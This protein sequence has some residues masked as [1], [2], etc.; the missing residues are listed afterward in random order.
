MERFDEFYKNL[1][2]YENRPITRTA[3]AYIENTKEEFIKYYTS[4]TNKYCKIYVDRYLKFIQLYI[5]LK[6]KP[7]VTGKEVVPYIPHQTKVK[8]P[9]RKSLPASLQIDNANL[10]P[11]DL[12]IPIVLNVSGLETEGEEQRVIM[13]KPGFNFE[14]GLRLDCLESTD[15]AK[16][17]DFF[18][19]AEC[20]H[21]TLSDTGKTELVKFLVAAKIKGAAKSRLGSCTVEAFDILKTTCINRI[22][23][24]EASSTLQLQLTS[25]SQGR[26]TLTEYGEQLRSLAKRLALAL[27]REQNATLASVETATRAMA[28]NQFKRGCHREV[29]P[30]VLAASPATLEEAVQTAIASNLDYTPASIMAYSNQ[31]YHGQRGQNYN[32]NFGRPNNFSN[33]PNSSNRYQNSQRYQNSNNSNYYNNSNYSNNRNSNNYNSKFNNRDRENNTHPRNDNNYSANGRGNNNNRYD[34]RRNNTG[35]RHQVSTID[36]QNQNQQGN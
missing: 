1:S 13:A 29:Q 3:L 5:R 12:S 6:T 20:Y 26:K 27:A 23:A 32:N 28:L 19:V 10:L 31:R 2:I 24:H 7:V 30:I 15:L 4:L 18:N 16:I 9:A 34:N 8:V 36:Q 33:N 11:L 17:Q 25:A 35:Y 14:V 21:N 22:A